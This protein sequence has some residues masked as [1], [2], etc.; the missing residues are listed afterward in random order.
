MPRAQQAL[1]S[2]PRLS[3]RRSRHFS[4]RWLFPSEAEHREVRLVVRIAVRCEDV[5]SADVEDFRRQWDRGPADD[6]TVNGHREEIRALC[7]GR[8]L[9][10][11]KDAVGVAKQTE[12]GR[13]SSGLRR[14]LKLR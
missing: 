8:C 11:P 2:P 1:R 4:K 12:V 10:D 5:I 14:L 3:R 6:F 13:K 9:L 7:A